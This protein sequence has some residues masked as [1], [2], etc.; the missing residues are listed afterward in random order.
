MLHRLQNI[1]GLIDLF[2][3]HGLDPKLIAASGFQTL[4]RRQRLIV[5]DIGLRFFQR[6]LIAR[7]VDSE[8]HLVF[9]HQLVILDAHLGN[10]P[11]NIRGNG[12]HI[13]AL[14]R[15]SRVHGDLV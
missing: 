7:L 11:G 1:V 13:C 8:Q 5:G 14:K 12:D 4:L 10:Q 9:L 6:L 15:A 2:P 3:R